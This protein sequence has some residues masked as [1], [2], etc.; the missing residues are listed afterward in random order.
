[1][2]ERAFSAIGASGWGRIDVMRSGNGDWFLLEANTV[3]G[4]TEKSLVPMA[5]KAAGLS[6]NDL[7]E[8]ILAQ[9]LER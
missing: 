9:T 1:L 3:P 2:A 7:V 8:R 5:A 4:M 6:F